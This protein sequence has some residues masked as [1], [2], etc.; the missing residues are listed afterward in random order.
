MSKTKTKALAIPAP[1]NKTEA[2]QML[3]DYSAVKREILREETRMND[4]IDAIK[5]ESEARI[6]EQKNQIK[7]LEK[8]IQTFCEANRRELTSGT[9]NWEAPTAFVK[10]R[11]LPASV[12][13]KGVETII[14]QLKSRKKFAGFLRT[15]YEVNKEAMLNNPSLAEE[16]EGVKIKS[17]GESFAIEIKEE[18][19]ADV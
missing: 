1:Q 13:L 16:I 5:T 9:Q 15:K 8:A 3:A 4:K 12:A 17:A 18:E 6:L 7:P 10:W 11:I 19:L 2:I 14:E